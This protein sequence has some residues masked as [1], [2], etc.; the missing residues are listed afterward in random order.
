MFVKATEQVLAYRE[1]VYDKFLEYEAL[2]HAVQKS[3]SPQINS[4]WQQRLL[5]FSQMHPL[6]VGYW[7]IFAEVG[8]YCFLEEFKGVHLTE[9]STPD[10]SIGR[11][12]CQHL[13]EVGYDMGRIKKYR[14]LYPDHR[15][16][17]WANLYPDDCLAEFRRWFPMYLRSRWQAYLQ[18]H[19]V[20]TPSEHKQL[21]PKRHRAKNKREENL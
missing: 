4:L 18:T 10:A 9:E 12:F 3:A 16:A 21:P 5:L 8:G 15:G 13:R 2:Q 14:H 11:S 20:P 1:Y 7:C 19:Q 6:P 17:Q